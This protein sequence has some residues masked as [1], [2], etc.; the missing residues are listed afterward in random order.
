MT[1]RDEYPIS[2]LPRHK[3][4]NLVPG[5]CHPCVD[6]F[7]SV[8]PA[9]MSMLR[10]LYSSTQISISF[11]VVGSCGWC[12][13]SCLSVNSRGYRP[14]GYHPREGVTPT[15]WVP[16][17]VIHAGAISLNWGHSSWR[18]DLELRC[19]LLG[20]YPSLG[21]QTGPFRPIWYQKGLFWSKWA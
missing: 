9:R 20:L 19:R 14:H 5:Q 1:P 16:A 7:T 11:S 8:A 17:K 6:G 10:L 15:I 21:Y 12:S 18:L 4:G 2:R 13:R 3:E